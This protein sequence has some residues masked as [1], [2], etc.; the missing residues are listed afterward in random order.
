MKWLVDNWA[1]IIALI[2]FAVFI[3]YFIIKFLNKPTDIQIANIKE[4]LKWAVTKA[5]KDLG[6]GTGQLKLRTVYNL[7]VEKFPFI[8]NVISFEVFSEWV[9]DALEWMNEQLETNVNIQ[10]LVNGGDLQ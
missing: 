9:D 4:W 10:N 6:S 5:E 8:L 1:I 7:A 3:V 2:C